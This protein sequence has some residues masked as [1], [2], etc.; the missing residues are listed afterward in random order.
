[1]VVHKYSFMGLAA[2][3]LAGGLGTANP[4]TAQEALSVAEATSVAEGEILTLDR[5]VI[6]AG[7]EKIAIETPQ[8]VTVVDQDAI[9]QEQGTTIG[10]VITDI[11]GV[12]A[13]G[14]ERMM[15]ESFN[16]RGIGGATAADEPR[17]IV[18]VD[19][20]VKFYEQY[21]MGSFFSD[22]ELYKRVEVLRG[23]ASS[24]LYGAGALAGVI[25]LATKDASDFLADG[26]D[27]MLREKLQ[28]G[29]NGNEFLTSTILAG[30]PGPNTEVLVTGNYRQSGSYKDGSGYKEDGTGGDSH[31]Q[32]GKLRHSF[33]PDRESAVTASL[34][35]WRSHQND[36][37]YSQTGLSNGVFN[38]FGT[39]DRRITDR[40]AVLKFEH[41]P[42][43]TPWLNL[44]V[45]GTFSS[46]LNEQSDVSPSLQNAFGNRWEGDYRTWQLR[47]ENS[48]EFRGEDWK[49]FLTYGLQTSKQDRISKAYR[50]NGTPF[51]IGSHPAGVTETYGAY[52]QSEVVYDEWL[53]LIP[54]IRI[55]NTDL[56]ADGSVSAT[57]TE[58]HHNYTLVSPKLAVHA[59]LTKNYALFGSVSHT[60]RAPVLDELYD[61]D[62]QRSL[63]PEQSN[64]VEGG[65]SV[66]FG[67]IFRPKDAFKSKFTLFYDDITDLIYRTA[68]GLAYFNAH[69]QTIHGGEIEA[70][71]DAGFAF[72]RIGAS[73]ISGK[74]F[75]GQNL[76]T[77][78]ADEVVVT[79]GGR[80]PERHLTFGYK[81]VKAFDQ[82]KVSNINA[83]AEGGGKP[84]YGYIVHNLF[85]TW[86][87]EEGVLAGT[88]F[89]L[90]IDNLLDRKYRQHLSG[91][92]APGR[93]VYVTVARKF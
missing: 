22:P 18:N 62:G 39:V 53:T 77:I 43:D 23:P 38:S 19:G 57:V 37:P 85:A 93:S 14:S 3:G 59:K 44:A 80:M 92:D 90:G 46:S 30:R 65:L 67:D 28:Y 11:P 34:Q 16:I 12:K 84:T 76:D 6:G 91:D 88:E 75:D 89:R 31:S 47:V 49:N 42:V 10:D 15:G 7:R 74:L 68:D 8:S 87:P 13:V 82:T 48:T 41:A 32:F 33:G 66:S 36:Q 71:Y 45:T 61:V 50:A 17:L 60:E 1:M 29:R 79:V 21:R 40:T 35:Q 25:N 63:Q 78:P 55:D 83:T 52:V 24:T 20:A 54:G 27:V 64:N 2:L 73:R 4:A 70:A 81:V 69:G 58:R 9:D 5:I 86:L 56:A 72:A 51:A 26:E